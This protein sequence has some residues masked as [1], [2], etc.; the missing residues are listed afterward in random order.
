MGEFAAAVFVKTRSKSK[1][2]KALVDL[3]AEHDFVAAK[4]GEAADREI[5][6]AD[7]G[8]GWVVVRDTA[9]LSVT[10][11]LAA[12]ARAVSAHAHPERRRPRTAT[13]RRESARIAPS[14][15]G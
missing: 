8:G 13:R 5:F 6:V 9:F 7:A 4:A 14:D 1:V 12:A 2:Q 11:S 15:Q 10:A 3:A